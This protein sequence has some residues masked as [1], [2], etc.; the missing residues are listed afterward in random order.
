[1]SLISVSNLTFA[2][3]GSY[4]NI[5]T[6]VSFQID[7][8]WKLGFCGRNG[9]GKTTFL[10]LL[11][12][13]LEYAG[14][15]SASVRF[16]YFPYTVENKSQNT[17]DVLESAAPDAPL[18]QI[19]KELSKLSV[20]EDALYR[21]FETLSSGEQTK[22]LLAGLF[23]RGHHFLLIDEPTNHLDMAS[24]EIAAKYLSSKS[25]FILVS[26]DRAFLDACVD[27]VLSINKANIEV[28]S[29]N[30]S[31]WWEQKRRQDE[32]EQAQNE[33][34]T[35]EI[36]RLHESAARTAQWS[37][38]VEKSKNQPL[39]SG[40][41]ADKGYIGH[42]AAKLMKRSKSTEKRRQGAA[43]EK[44]GL[45]KNIEQA[46]SLKITPLLYH[47]SRL[48]SLDKVSLFY[49]D[50]QICQNVS[51]TLNQGGR[52]AL[53][54]GNG[55]GKSSILKL[56]LGENISHTGD[57]NIHSR[58]QISYVPQD[59]SFLSGNLREY[60]EREQI[61]ETL[62]KAILRKLDFS[63]EQF[64]KDMR[65]Y[66]AG[67]KKK[68]AIARSLCQSAHLYIWDEPL[69]Y[70]DVYSRIQLEELIA[71]YCPTLLFVEHDRAFCEN[72]ATEVVRL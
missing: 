21:P 10:K 32:F 14:A 11:M 50:K 18:W 49:G 72:I 41:S 43:E 62:F 44:S 51:F 16:D 24:R 9:R 59:A 37:D 57:V 7:T 38:R 48:L 31:T 61:D 29:G 69:N 66:S 28:T 60:C 8:D 1:M 67:Q 64:G 40:L 52:V 15:I 39:K 46:E 17:L 71:A 55:S 5:F 42:K 2:Y 30:F 19:Q 23:L 70:I 68:A 65:D 63:R 54:G 22:A 34:L 33:K 6:D 3:D 36:G 12:G 27:H 53:S 56:I 45:L 13:Q 20:G 35:R 25:G 26:H 4:D 58:L 47:S